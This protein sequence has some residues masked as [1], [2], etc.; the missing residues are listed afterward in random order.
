MT[1]V[2][3]YARVST[4][5]QAEGGKS[6]AAQLAEMREFAARRDWTVAAEF[7]DPGLSG[8]TMDRPALRNLLL[9]AEQHSFDILLVHELSRLSRRLFDTFR[10]FDQLGKLNVG[11]A[12][13]K[14]PDF[15]F[16]TPTGRLFLTI[17]AALHQYYIDLL[18]MHTR[19]SK[20]QRAREG[21]YNASITPFG[22][23]HT[24]DANTPPLI[25]PE[26]ARAVQEI[27]RRYATG[28]YSYQEVADWI[29]DSGF[30]TR[31]GRRFSKDTIADML[32]NPFYKGFV[33][34]G[35]GRRDQAAKELFPGKHQPLVGPELW[36]ACRRIREQ[37]RGAPRTYQPK[38]RVYLLN[39]IA[40][41]DV[42]GRKLRA[43]GATSGSYYREMSRARGFIDCPAASSGVRTDVIEEQIG[44]IFR[45][46]HLP[47]DWQ[48][49]LEELLDREGD[50]QT[51]ESR[52]ARLIAER[53]RLKEMYVRGEFDEDP[54]L[55]DQEQARIRRELAEL[56]APADLETIQRAA[57]TLEE[58]A[59]VWDEAGP[60]DR[61]DLLR[62]ALREV[63]VDMTQGRLATIE[64]YPVF[65]PLFR[66]VP[67]LREVSFGVFVP[68]WP[69]EMAGEV[70]TA[71]VLPLLAVAP[72][73]QEAPDRPLVPTLP[74][75]LVGQ[76][77]TPVLSEWLKG[78]RRQGQEIGRVIDLAHPGVPSLRVDSRKWPEVRLERVK[79]LQALPE[80]S[81]SFLWTPFALQGAED[82]ATAVEKA[83]RVLAPGGTWAFVDV[84]PASMPGHWL[85]RFF[86]RV[87][88]NEEQSAWD[89]YRTYNA[90]VQAGFGVQLRRRTFHQAVTLE[91]ARE[92]ARARES[93]PQLAALP[94]EAYAAGLAAL[95]EAMER[96][97]P[98]EAI[99]S[100]F[101]LVEVT[102]VR[103]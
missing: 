79:D 5:M 28:R 42:C 89:V 90:L 99:G 97:G 66:Q 19:K 70:D 68:L 62:L 100:E 39:G 23:R 65:V 55:Y 88:E 54:D 37:R 6:I 91:V 101:C 26:E 59:Q 47:T 73:P 49:R 34:Y 18:K 76:R 36:D 61:R 75:E 8:T 13:V 29:N 46:L 33:A 86:P 21:L 35:Q 31:S 3:I 20:R 14:E 10:I 63:K 103:G 77:I 98:G 92:I 69:P 30:R 50:R 1:R 27:F 67:L 56:P 7:V 12:S 57:A 85:Y 74:G 78:R 95:G 38:Y 32:R 45:H 96:E 4:D 84:M 22:Y 53:R 16:S 93:C 72:D 43:Q 83:R 41:C 82:R 11:F 25:V 17:L 80:G 40:T 64:P 52:R 87:F 81:V 9:A 51:L 44:A 60:A 48:A 71:P 94:D 15:D 58:L 2:A 102:A 24:G